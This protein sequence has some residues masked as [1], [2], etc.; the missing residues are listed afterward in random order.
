MI[1]QT[2]F[3]THLDLTKVVQI[4]DA[5]YDDHDF[6]FAFEITVQLCDRPI[7]FWSSSG[8]MAKMDGLHGR[9]SHLKWLQEQVEDLVKQWKQAKEIS[10]V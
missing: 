3:G 8:E 5:Y 2:F 7:E 1:V 4:T 9:D 10:R 6:G